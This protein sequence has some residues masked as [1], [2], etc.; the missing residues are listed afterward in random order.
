LAYQL[1]VRVGPEVGRE[2]HETLAEALDAL[3]QRLEA[4][5]DAARRN[6]AQGFGREYAPVAQV[7]ARGEVAGPTGVRGWLMGGVRAGADVRGDGSVE[8]YRGRVRRELVTVRD[9]ETPFDALRRELGVTDADG[10]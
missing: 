2:R 4:L 9:D 8:T 5:G 1:T 10:G 3:Q 7:G 6:T